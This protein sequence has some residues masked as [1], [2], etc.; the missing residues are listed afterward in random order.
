MDTGASDTQPR[1]H[2]VLEQPLRIC[3]VLSV[4]KVKAKLFEHVLQIGLH[5]VTLV[6][7]KQAAPDIPLLPVLARLCCLARG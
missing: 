1:S 3:Q 2:Q 4:G 7:V 5:A 6:V